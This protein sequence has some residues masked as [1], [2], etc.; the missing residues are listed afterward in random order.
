MCLCCVCRPRVPLPLHLA[1]VED[2][3]GVSAGQP[4]VGVPEVRP[5]EHVRESNCVRNLFHI[6]TRHRRRQIGGRRMPIAKKANISDG[7]SLQSAS[8]YTVTRKKNH[9][10]EIKRVMKKQSRQPNKQLQHV[11]SLCSRI[12]LAA[13]TEPRATHTSTNGTKKTNAQLSEPICQSLARRAT[14]LDPTALPTHL[15]CY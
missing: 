14:G 11:S 8:P 1:M 5:V 13:A 3:P 10:K 9:T 12:S 4:R 7:V 15:S 2:A 6:Q